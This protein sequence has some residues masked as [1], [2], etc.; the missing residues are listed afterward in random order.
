VVTDTGIGIARQEQERVF[1]PF[2][3]IDGRTD[4]R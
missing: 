3:Q 1:A 2:Q 4:R